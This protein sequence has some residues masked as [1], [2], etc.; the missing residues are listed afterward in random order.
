DAMTEEAAF[1]LVTRRGNVEFREYAEHV[2]ASVSVSGT[3][4]SAP[5]VG[6]RPL[7]G[8]ISG[9]NR[10]NTQ[11]AMT[12]PVFHEA[13][14]D[15]SHVISFVLPNGTTQVPDPMRQGVTTHVVPALTVAAI[16]FTGGWNTQRARGYESRLLR[17]LSEWGIDPVGATLFARYDPP[18]KP[19]FLRRNEVL[20]PI[21]S[22]DVPSN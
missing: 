4:E 21:N 22:S 20:V 8:Y 6:F 15:S 17:Q 5:S 16:R 19:G 9:E 3:F 14:S 11:L 13:A 12:A 18:W 1:R 2:L 10:E 7:V